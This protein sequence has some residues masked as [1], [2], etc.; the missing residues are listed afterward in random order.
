MPPLSQYRPRMRGDTPEK[1]TTACKTTPMRM[2][3]SVWTR[4]SEMR[5]GL[6][7]HASGLVEGSARK[8]R[9]WTAI[10]A[11][12][13]LHGLEG[14]EQ[15]A[16]GIH[17]GCQVRSGLV[18]QHAHE[19]DHWPP[20]PHRGLRCQ[21]ACSTINADWESHSLCVFWRSYTQYLVGFHEV[22]KVQSAK[23]WIKKRLM[24]CLAKMAFNSCVDCG[25]APVRD[26][27]SQL[28]TRAM[29]P[30]PTNFRPA[31]TRAVARGPYRRKQKVE[32]G[33]GPTTTSEVPDSAP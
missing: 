7:G 32:R 12:E 31:P 27:A 24:V 29:P 28:C 9:G 5:R 11:G 2:P 10:S 4:S 30:K 17:A 20:L 15:L 22:L 16:A 19:G 33:P 25:A 1:R 13:L 8:Q 18:L 14:S 3:T 6:W 26:G 21:L 23:W